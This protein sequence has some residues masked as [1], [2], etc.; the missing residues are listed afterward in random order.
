MVHFKC[1]AGCTRCK[2]ALPPLSS[3][4]RASLGIAGASTSESSTDS[5]DVR[6][7]FLGGGGGRGGAITARFAQHPFIPAGGRRVE[8]DQGLLCLCEHRAGHAAV[9]QEQARHGAVCTHGRWHHDPGAGAPRR[10]HR[11]SPLSPAPCQQG[12][13]LLRPAILSLIPSHPAH[14]VFR[15]TQTRSR[16]WRCTSAPSCAT[17]QGL[18]ASS[19]PGSS[20]AVSASIPNPPFSSAERSASCPPGT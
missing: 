17:A 14:S 8:P 9:L 2:P 13:V 4:S 6:E 18:A 3:A 12:D 1:A 16:M 10:P 19:R 15:K 7:P 11:L 5:D 20:A